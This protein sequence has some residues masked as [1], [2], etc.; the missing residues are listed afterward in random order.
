MSRDETSA[1]AKAPRNAPRE[2]TPGRIRS[3]WSVLLGERLVPVQLQA[4]WVEYKLI[5]DDLL[6]RLSAQLARQAK[7]EKGR[8]ETQ[9]PMDE[10]APLVRAPAG[11]KA[12][13]RRRAAVARGIMPQAST[14]SAP[15]GA[16][17]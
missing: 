8:L 5:F 17:R 6:K 9:L 7:A 16:P 3:A 15:N 1:G 2:R 10:P 4:E 11:N 14:I 13:L 12:E